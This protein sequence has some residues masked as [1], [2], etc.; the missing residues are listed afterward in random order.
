MVREGLISPAEAIKRLEGVDLEHA[1][2]A[3]LK[4]ELAPLAKAV[5]AS[6]GM[7]SGNIALDSGTAERFA[8]RGDSVILVRRE[9]S[10]DDVAGFNV[11]A[12]ILT[13]IGGR[14]AHAAVVARQLGKVC[15]VGCRSLEIDEVGRCITLAGR[16]LKEGD[17]LSINGESGEI[18]AGRA[19]VVIERPEV[20]MAELSRWRDHVALD[21]SKR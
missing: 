6:P 17:W 21:S 1:G 2:R 10:T 9:P 12:G 5:P 19:E 4:G 20:E 16:E 7:A 15:L 3:V 18:F 11:A 8:A 13:M 14:T